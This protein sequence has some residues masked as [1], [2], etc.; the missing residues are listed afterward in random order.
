MKKRLTALAWLTAA[1]LLLAGCSAPAA[2]N[3]DAASDEP[4]ATDA[5]AQNTE[6]VSLTNANGMD[7][8]FSNRELS[9]TYEKAGATLV[10]G[11]NGNISI[12]GSGAQLDGSNLLIHGGV[13]L[14]TGSIENTCIIVD[15][16]NEKVQLVLDNASISNG[17]GPAL[18]I[19]SADKVFITLP[20]GSV[21]SLIDGADYTFTDSDTTVDAAVFSLADLAVNGSGTLYI[22]GQ[23]K[24]GIVSKDD[25]VVAGCALN[26]T[27]ASTALDGKDCI[28]AVNTS[29]N[30][31]AGSNGLRSDNAEDPL[32]GFVYLTQ[33]VVN[34][35]AGK[36]GIQAETLFKAA[37]CSLNIT[38][39]G[40]SGN[41]L[42]Y[43]TDSFKGLKAG[44]DIE[45]SGGSC[46]ISS[47]DDCIHANGNLLISSGGY[48]LASGDD[49]LHADTD[50]TIAGG[51]IRI[52]KSYEG[53]EASKITIS[54][55]H[56]DLVASDDGLNAA[57]GADSSAMGGRFGR[58]MFSS[59]VG[60]I[61]IEGG[62][63][64][65]NASGDG[66][67]SNANIS[68]SGG[69]TLVSGPASSG[70]AAFDYDGTATVTG[71][72][73]IATGSS[74]MAQSFTS[75]EN[76]GAIL[77][78]LNR[79]QSGQ[80]LALLDNDDQVVAAFT[81]QTAYQSAVLTAPGILEG[82]TY[83]ITTGAA[84]SDADV[85]GFAQSGTASGGTVQASVEMTSL[86]YGGGGGMW[87]MGP[88]GGGG[89][90]MWNRGPGGG[91]MRNN[92]PG[93]G[94][95]PPDSTA[96]PPDGMNP[97]PGGW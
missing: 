63:T 5:P 31:T 16:D 61:F 91:G 64:V 49:G 35:T 85:N 59:G 45:L 32:R 83:T 30:I 10:S 52:E 77:V 65:I 26:V 74:G 66:I 15:A 19:R 90:G 11:E 46:S 37:D 34:V 48:T 18:F 24:H 4:S 38:T 79:Q 89:G 88:G 86:L 12:D 27:A 3:A 33:S 17:S 60:E 9:G 76:Q 53:I 81:P 73:L 43:S 87:N 50:L 28:K 22:S 92:M 72:I 69:V 55:G 70:N 42:R 94:N 51:S 93:G 14:L 57:G 68:V 96:N 25:L 82:Q 41:T 54:G 1:S 80:T 58:G 75:A 78:N 2:Q 95:Q 84:L 6:V 13:C 29:M 23:Y 36:D 62:Y 21:S 56:I 71:G 20:D 39:G 47:A 7:L 8:T 40:G 67:D 44:T 97:P